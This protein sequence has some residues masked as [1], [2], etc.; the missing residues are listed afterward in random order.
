LRTPKTSQA[1]NYREQP[2]EQQRS[3]EEAE[4]Y[5]FSSGKTLTRRGGFSCCAR[6]CWRRS[7]PRRLSQ[8]LPM[9]FELVRIELVFIQESLAHRV[10]AVI[11]KLTHQ[12]GGHDPFAAGVGVAFDHDVGVAKGARQLA[13][14][15]IVAGMVES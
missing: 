7:C 1:H 2:D 3:K 5:S 12:V 14:L 11:G 9:T 8:P 15:F 10:S 13:D 6:H 4:H